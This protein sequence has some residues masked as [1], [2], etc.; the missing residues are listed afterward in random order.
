MVSFAEIPVQGKLSL[1]DAGSYGGGHH[2]RDGDAREMKQ[3]GWILP[4]QR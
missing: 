1:Y 3:R 2:L 4:E